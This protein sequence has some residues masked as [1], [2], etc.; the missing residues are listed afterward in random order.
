MQNESGAGGEESGQD[1]MNGLQLPQIETPTP[2]HGAAWL[3]IYGHVQP[4]YV[5]SVEQSAEALDKAAKFRTW[6]DAQDIVVRAVYLWALK[7]IESR[8]QGRLAAAQIGA[9]VMAAMRTIPMP[10]GVEA[11]PWMQR[12]G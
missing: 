5:N 3:V 10:P 6:A 12:D 8:I 9:N 4:D 2:M 7:D 11:E 1:S